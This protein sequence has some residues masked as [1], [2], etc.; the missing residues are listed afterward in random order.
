MPLGGEPTLSQQRDLTVAAG[1]HNPQPDV[2]GQ[3]DGCFLGHG[4][5]LSEATLPDFA[6]DA[7]PAKSGKGLMVSA[8]SGL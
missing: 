1:E 2:V 7:S 5:H 3:L 8:H 6:G 4:R